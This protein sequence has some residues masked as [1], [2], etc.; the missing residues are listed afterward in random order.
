MADK[1]VTIP[2]TVRGM[3]TPYESDFIRDVNPVLSRLG[4]NAG[5]CHGANK[6]KNGFKLSLRGVDAVFDAPSSMT[7]PRAAST[8]RPP[9]T[10]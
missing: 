9:T 7:M 2:V 4:C 8:S 5:T 3:K 6:G 10:A 1:V